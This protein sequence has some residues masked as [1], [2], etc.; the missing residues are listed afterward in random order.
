SP[1]SP[2]RMPTP[3]PTAT[4]DLEVARDDLA[5]TRVVER[6]LPEPAPGQA[7]LRVERFGLSANNITYAVLGDALGYWSFFPAEQPWGCIPVW[8][9]AEVVAGDAL[10]QGTRVFGYCPMS[11]H[12]LVAPDRIDEGGFADASPHRAD[13]PPAYNS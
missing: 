1:R 7:L 2:A 8:G 11:T 5:R 4:A 10:P 3:S 9:F 6:A 12:M 13:L